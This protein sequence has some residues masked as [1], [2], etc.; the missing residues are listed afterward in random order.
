MY[1][2]ITRIYNGNTLI[3]YEILDKNTNKKSILSVE[4]TQGL[5]MAGSVINATF[6][7]SKGKLVGYNGFDLRTIPKKQEKVNYKISLNNVIF[8]G[9]DLE[10]LVTDNTATYMERYLVEKVMN[11]LYSS[12]DGKICALYGLRRTGKTVMMYH[13]IKRLLKD[14]HKNAAYITL[15][16]NHSLASVFNTLEKLVTNNIQY[17][18]IDEITAVNGFIQ[19]SALLADKYAKMGIHIVIAG[20][21]SYVLQIAGQDNL[22]DRMVKINTTYIGYKEYEYLNPNTTILEYIRMGGVMPADIFYNEEKT[23]DYINTAI[24]NNIINSLQRANNRKEHQLLLELNE[25][26]L[27]KKAIEQTVTAA[28]EILTASVITSTY[29]NADLGSAKQM[30]EGIFDI[31]STLDTEEVEERVRYKLS[32]VKKFDAEINSEYIEELKDFLVDIGVIKLY[33][34]YVGK[35]KIE[36]PL[37]VQ[38][39][40]RYHQTVALI[41]A[42]SETSSFHE[43]S[44]DI[45]LQLQKKIIEDVEGNLIEH[46]VILSALKAFEDTNVKVTQFVYKSKEIDMM[47]Q[48]NNELYL[49]E[50]KRNAKI[51]EKQYRWLENKELN[52]FIE[53]ESGSKIKE[54]VVLYLGE[55]KKINAPTNSISYINISEFLKKKM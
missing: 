48:K 23:K 21:D 42:L 25:R 52:D 34:R 12:C 55:S 27:L 11:F 32:I 30:L 4:Q 17:V 44:S 41:N 38:P 10:K 13:A 8:I 37:F 31:N 35:R 22:Y 28:N 16:E 50:V 36:V 54:R 7:I 53:S 33:Y 19:S 18:F 49:F 20:T 5:A 43:L 29:H 6:D 39:G 47:I 40:L 26:G 51:N 45:R 9:K 46:E 1:E 14:G 2:I 24:S 3:K 15:T